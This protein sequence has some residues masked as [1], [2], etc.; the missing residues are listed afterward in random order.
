MSIKLVSRSRASNNRIVNVTNAATPT[1]PVPRTFTISP[2]VGGKTSWNLDTDGTLTLSSAGT[3]SLTA[4]SSFTGNCKIWG[5]G[6]GAGRNHSSCPGGGGGFSVAN[7]NFSSGVVYSIIVGE[8]GR[9]LDT[10]GGGMTNGSYKGTSGYGRGGA[11]TQYGGSGGGGTGLTL[12][13]SPYTPIL[14]AGGGGGGASELG[15]AGAG[16][17]TNGGNGSGTSGQGAQGIIP[18]TGVQEDTAATAWS[19]SSGGDGGYGTYVSGGGGGGYAGGGAMDTNQ[20]GGGGGGSGYVNSA[21]TS[22]T[23]T[24]VAGSGSTAAASSDTDKPANT[25][26]GATSETRAYPGAFV[27]K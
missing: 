22:G 17:G 11:A 20:N 23:G 14:V 25:A 24:T 5:A 19:G 3:W 26:T 15:N 6:G 1:G 4:T 7:V 10:A 13:A 2:A 8:G 27:L 12:A 16:G 21:Y 9:A 18:G